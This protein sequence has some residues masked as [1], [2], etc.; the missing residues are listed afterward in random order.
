M[1]FREEHNLTLIR[2][3][4]M[5]PRIPFSEI[6]E[7]LLGKKYVLSI[8][9]I[10]PDEAKELNIRT[11]QKD[12]T[13][14]V[15]SF[16]LSETEGEIYICLSVVRKGAKEFSMSYQKFLNLIVIH[17]AL[18]LKGHEHSSTMEDMEEKLLNKFYR[19]EK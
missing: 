1:A 19:G 3:N 11:R 10:G 5:L 4:G 15:L 2:K 17:G 14:N 6:K 16:P 13:P 8:N 12:Y 18:H 7:S 9:F